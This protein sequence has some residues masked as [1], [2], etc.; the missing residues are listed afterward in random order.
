MKNP[1]CGRVPGRAGRLGDGAEVRSGCTS[2]HGRERRKAGWCLDRNWDGERVMA[3]FYQK[4][5]TVCDVVGV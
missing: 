4:C 1:G 5:R 2:K 3:G